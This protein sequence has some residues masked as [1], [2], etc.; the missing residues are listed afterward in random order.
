[1]LILPST[2]L[3]IAGASL[4]PFPSHPYVKW[5]PTWTTHMTGV[6]NHI[7]VPLDATSVTTP[8]APSNWQ[9]LLTEHP[10]QQLVKFFITGITNGFRIGFNHSQESL[11]SA[12]KNIFCAIQHPEVVDTYLT[13]EISYCRVAGP[14]FPHLVPN[15]HISR[16][17]VIPKHLQPI[18]SG[19]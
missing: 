11:R 6:S 3:M 5:L 9:V 4:C 12:K 2:A 13:E 14:F 19:F 18:T 15:A 16:F 10:N 17:G 7:H 1:M 8:L